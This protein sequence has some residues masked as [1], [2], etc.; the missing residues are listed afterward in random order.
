M[1][2][3]Y[4]AYW[5]VGT[6]ALALTAF[7]VVRSGAYGYFR[8]KREHFDWVRREIGGENVDKK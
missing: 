2:W 1:N 4:A 5:V 8:S 6:A 7:V 3:L